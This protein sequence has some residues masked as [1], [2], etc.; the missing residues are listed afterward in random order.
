[1]KNKKKEIVVE[2]VV[3]KI[4]NSNIF[5]QFLCRSLLERINEC[6]FLLDLGSRKFLSWKKPYKSFVYIV[7]FKKD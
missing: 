2:A 4:L 7:A 5:L 6:L 3:E 1:M